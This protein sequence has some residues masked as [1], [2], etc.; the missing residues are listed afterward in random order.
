[1]DIAKIREGTGRPAEERITGMVHI[2]MWMRRKGTVMTG[3][4]ETKLTILVVDDEEQI[5]SFITSYLTQEGYRVLTA[6]NGPEALRELAKYPE[7]DLVILDWMMPGMSGLD[8]CRTIRKTSD[9]PLIFLTSKSDELDKLLGLEMGADDYVTK[10]FSIRELETRIRVVMR[11]RNLTLPVPAQKSTVADD[12]LVVRGSLS[13]NL[14]KH[15]VTVDGQN[16]V[17]TPTEFKI[18]A[19]LAKH[20]GRVF[21]RLDLLELA[22]GEEYSGYERTIDTHVRNVRKKIEKDFSNPYFIITVFGIG[23]KFGESV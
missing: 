22:L 7:T 14:G 23:Y 11:R 12:E 1:M 9:V 3:M 17:L 13:M 21:S 10:P 20:P 6:G 18:L 16:V 8:V 4:Q 15:Q 2:D 5:V 19:T